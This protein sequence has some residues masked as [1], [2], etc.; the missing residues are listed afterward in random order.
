MG[1]REERTNL[2]HEPL[3]DPRSETDSAIYSTSFQCSHSPKS[4]KV[5]I[6]AS[7]TMRSNLKLREIKSQSYIGCSR[8]GFEFQSS[9]LL[10]F[11]ISLHY[12]SVFVFFSYCGEYAFGKHIPFFKDTSPG[13]TE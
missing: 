3:K 6:I 1:L 4:Y 12:I 2:Y 11:Q 13:A 8:I 5:N 7:V 10:L 9:F